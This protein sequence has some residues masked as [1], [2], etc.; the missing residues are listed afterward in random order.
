M[1]LF[2]KLK[3]LLIKARI[4]RVA[5]VQGKTAGVRLLIVLGRITGSWHHSWHTSWPLAV[6]TLPV[7]QF[8][9]FMACRSSRESEYQ[10]QALTMLYSC[11]P[12][13]LLPG[14]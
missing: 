13:P 12:R 4:K 3:L 11:A 14:P 8:K 7:V 5:E 9:R 1:P 10:K 6:F 2:R